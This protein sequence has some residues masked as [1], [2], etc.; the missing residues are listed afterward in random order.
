MTVLSTISVI[1]QHFCLLYTSRCVSE[2]VLKL[3]RVVVVYNDSLLIDL[4]F[5][6]IHFTDSDTYYILVV[7][8]CTDKNL[9]VGIDV[10]KRQSSACASIDIFLWM[11][12][13]PPCLAIA[14]AIFDSVT[15]YIAALIIGM[16]RTIFLVRCV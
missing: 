5:T 10:Y 7:V 1:L 11:I 9:C 8:D 12:P 2:T 16:L 13:I 4:D 14:I 6:V 3:V 15:V